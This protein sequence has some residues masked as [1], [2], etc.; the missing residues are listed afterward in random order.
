MGRHIAVYGT[1][2]HGREIAWMVQKQLVDSGDVL[3]GFVDDNVRNVG[4]KVNGIE[5]FSLEHVASEHADAQMI[6]AVGAP[7]LRET[8][9]RKCENRNL[10]F[11]TLLYKGAML[12][13]DV[14][15]GE[16][17][18][19]CEGSVI[20][21]NISVGRHVHINIG[22]SISHDV[23]IGDFATIN[24]GAR[25]NGWVYI[26]SRA[27]IGAGAVV[28]NGRPGKPLAIGEGAVVGAGACVIR[29][30]L[31]GATVVGVPAKPITYR[32]CTNR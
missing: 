27:Y 2:G 28:S 15:F 30:V 19:L 25:I 29:P 22:C 26:G 1:G 9:A 24:P 18:V 20:T 13:P 10:A 14:S 5:V 6:C 16:G 8:L 3:L 32:D 7:C 17:S 11:A 31:A 21:T 12:S 4:T 23:T